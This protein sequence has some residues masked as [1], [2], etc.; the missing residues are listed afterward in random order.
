MP[1]SPRRVRSDVAG[2]WL[3]LQQPLSVCVCVVHVQREGSLSL[4]GTC[5]ERFHALPDTLAVPGTVS[6]QPLLRG[7]LQVRLAPGAEGQAQA[8]EKITG[9]GSGRGSRRNAP[10]SRKIQPLFTSDRKGPAS[11]ISAANPSSTLWTH[12]HDPSKALL[13]QRPCVPVRQDQGTLSN[14]KPLQ[15]LFSGPIPSLL[16]SARPSLRSQHHSFPA[17][18]QRAMAPRTHPSGCYRAESSLEP[19]PPHFPD[20]LWSSMGHWGQHHLVEAPVKATGEP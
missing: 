19:P 13:P 18:T 5:L 1:G 16:A 7:R 8:G 11:L 9:E 14:P 6:M 12:S 10:P 3:L 2:W 4:L 20:S 17:R 15:L